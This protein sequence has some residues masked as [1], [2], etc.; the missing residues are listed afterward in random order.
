MPPHTLSL[1]DAI[2]VEFEKHDYHIATLL[3]TNTRKCSYVLILQKIVMVKKDA[4]LEK[5]YETLEDPGKKLS[6]AVKLSCTGVAV[7]QHL[8]QTNGL[9][10][11]PGLCHNSV[12][13]LSTS[14]FFHL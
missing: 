14:S 6:I 5:V 9:E 12:S 13:G 7:G 10:T 8:E 4:I 11:A 3:D 2:D 1:E